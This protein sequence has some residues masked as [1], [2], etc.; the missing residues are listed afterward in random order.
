M[1]EVAIVFGRH[2]LPPDDWVGRLS[3]STQLLWRVLLANG[4]TLYVV[5]RDQPVTEGMADQLAKY[6][7]EALARVG[8]K[9]DLTPPSIR[10]MLY[11]RKPT[12][13]ATSSTAARA[14][15]SPWARAT[16]APPWSNLG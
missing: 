5:W 15:G 8:P 7:E 9:I 2:P 13:P 1:I 16:R 4:E 12:A 3:M 11:G 10:M 6:K 14:R